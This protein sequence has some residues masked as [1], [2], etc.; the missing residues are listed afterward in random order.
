[1]RAAPL[2]CDHEQ[3]PPVRA[4]EHTGKAA[5]VNNIFISGIDDFFSNA[6]FHPSRQLDFPPA[7]LS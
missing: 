7:N 3:R 2:G 4:T 6:G 5:P 1:L